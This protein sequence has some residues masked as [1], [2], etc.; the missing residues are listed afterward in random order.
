[1]SAVT[2]Y[3]DELLS[4]DSNAT[5]LVVN[6]SLCM[7]EL[8]LSEADYALYRSWVSVDNMPWSFMSRFLSPKKKS[9]NI[10]LRSVIGNSLVRQ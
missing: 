2:D 7:N 5:S 1:M 10:K 3:E 9:S 4:T 6:C 8:C